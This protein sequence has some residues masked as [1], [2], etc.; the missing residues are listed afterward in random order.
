M[1]HVLVLIFII[2]CPF[3]S[4]SVELGLVLA[5]LLLLPCQAFWAGRRSSGGGCI[6]FVRRASKPRVTQ[7]TC[8]SQREDC[9]NLG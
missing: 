3:L 5:V 9:E 1:L 2:L 8:A 4:A 6:E 7:P